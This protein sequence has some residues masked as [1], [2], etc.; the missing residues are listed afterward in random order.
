VHLLSGCGFTG[1][2]RRKNDFI[3]ALWKTTGRGTFIRLFCTMVKR[4]GEQPSP[5]L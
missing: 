5:I 4:V 2:P 1:G 3:P